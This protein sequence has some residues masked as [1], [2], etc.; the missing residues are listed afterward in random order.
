MF[1][2]GE[3]SSS[4]SVDMPV[5]LVDTKGKILESTQQVVH[6]SGQESFEEA[7]A[8]GKSKF[9]DRDVVSMKLGKLHAEAITTFNNMKM[10][11]YM[12]KNRMKPSATCLYVITA[13]AEVK[14]SK[15]ARKRKDSDS[16]AHGDD[17]SRTSSSESEDSDDGEEPNLSFQK[18]TKILESDI[19]K[20]EEIGS[21]T[22]ARVYKGK[23]QG[24][25]VT[26]KEN[27]L[28][29]PQ[30][31]DAIHT[32]LLQEIALHSDLAHPNVVQFFGLCKLE[33][34][35]VMVTEL[36]HTSLANYT[37]N[38]DQLQTLTREDKLFFSIE[39]IK[40]LNYLHSRNIVHGDLKPPNILISLDK[41]QIK[42]CD[43]GL[44]RLKKSV[45]ATVTQSPRQGTYLYMSPQI[46]LQKI[47]CTFACDIWALGGT[48]AE[49]FTGED[50]WTVPRDIS[51]LST[52][53][54]KS[55]K[56][57]EEP[58]AMA[59]LK[60]LDDAV[61]NAVSCCVSYDV[62]GRPNLVDLRDHLEQILSG[63]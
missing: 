2:P 22:Q 51:K 63:Q 43:M 52:C 42:L 20:L 6:F 55:M 50:L 59:R 3:T 17:D 38:R 26:L 32:Q 5:R 8:I 21:G 48:I 27:F 9:P 53:M 36:L 58:P 39:M 13:A 62:S 31:T 44:S 49:L 35:V 34:S 45:T 18:V 23:W 54:R 16:Q 7:F 25:D 1:Q 37:F 28:Q 12:R 46:Q 56:K 29:S 40:G 33:R 60:E 19:E 11:E 4:T 10:R 47:R 30:L 57:K 14:P 24:T 41:K 61:Y 15:R